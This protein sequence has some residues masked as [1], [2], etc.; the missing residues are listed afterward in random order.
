MQLDQII[1]KAIKNNHRAQTRLYE[2]Y[3]YVWYSICLRYQNNGADA[4]DALQ[5]ALIKIYGKIRQFDSSKGDFK[6]WSCKVVV[7]ENLMLIRKNK[8]FL[9]EYNDGLSESIHDREESPLDILSA[10]ELTKIIQQLP[11]GYRTIFN[12]YVIEGFSHKEIANRLN[13][14]EGTSKSQLFKAKK[15][16][17]QMLEVL[18]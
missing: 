16:L 1:K 5:N 6:S 13:I 2:L 11:D 18:I 8:N 17:K 10:E 15:Q 4:K 7:N 3:G 14:S 9:K 12:L